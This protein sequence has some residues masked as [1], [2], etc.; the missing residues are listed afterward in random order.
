M[1]EIPGPGP[2]GAPSGSS[3]NEGEDIH[4]TG[5]DQKMTEERVGR[6][7]QL[8][9]DLMS[10]KKPLGSCVTIALVGEVFA[11]AIL[12]GGAGAVGD[13][14]AYSIQPFYSF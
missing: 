1:Q 11:E 2:E 12:N 10:S 5:E 4:L 13:A 7:Q 9:G 8:L 6:E 14:E 3:G